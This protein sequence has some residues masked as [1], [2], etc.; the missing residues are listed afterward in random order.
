MKRRKV[1]SGGY[2]HIFR[3]STLTLSIAAF[4]ILGQTGYTNGWRLGGFYDWMGDAFIVIL[5]LY[6]LFN[7]PGIWRELD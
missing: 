7:L 1:K 6:F 2:K 4:K 5:A 3:M